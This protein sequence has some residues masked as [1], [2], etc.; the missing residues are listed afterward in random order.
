MARCSKSKVPVSEHGMVAA[1]ALACPRLGGDAELGACREG[2]RGE[3][4]VLTKKGVF[5]SQ[6]R[7]TRCVCEQH[8]LDSAPGWHA[9]ECL[10]YCRQSTRE[11]GNGSKKMRGFT[12]NLASLPV[13]AG[14]CRLF[15]RNLQMFNTVEW[16]NGVGVSLMRNDYA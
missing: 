7:E 9:S 13:R 1:F 5:V 16:S 8:S 10:P 14:C 12:K 4:E 2:K 15:N 6:Y 3:W 11:D